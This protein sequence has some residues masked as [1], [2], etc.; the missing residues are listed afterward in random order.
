MLRNGQLI[1]IN[2]RGS[3]IGYQRDCLMRSKLNKSGIIGQSILLPIAAS[4]L[5]F[6]FAKKLTRGLLMWQPS[7]NI[8]KLLITFW[9]ICWKVAL[10][11][12]LWEIP[13]RIFTLKIAN[14]S[15]GF[16]IS[17]RYLRVL[18]ILGSCYQ[19]Y[20]I[21]F[22]DIFKGLPHWHTKR[23]PFAILLKNLKFM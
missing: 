15:K 4:V 10:A 8:P 3:Q 2:P 14:I 11:A 17:L 19:E 18:N 20:W 16:A 12:I 21:T 6:K 23:Q 5:N 1:Y 22:R 9:W 7:R 13:P